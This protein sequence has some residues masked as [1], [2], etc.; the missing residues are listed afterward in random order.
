MDVDPAG[1]A[2]A[3]GTK[4]RALEAQAQDHYPSTTSSGTHPLSVYSP[5][6]AAARGIFR[7]GRDRASK[8]LVSTKTYTTAQEEGEN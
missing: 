2:R 8:R 3:G 5:L 4:R 1:N 6:I 7:N